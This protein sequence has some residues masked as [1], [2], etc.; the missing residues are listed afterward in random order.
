MKNEKS[1]T[2]DAGRDIA[3]T[4]GYAE[5]FMRGGLPAGA[6]DEGIHSF[7]VTV[8]AIRSDLVEQYKANAAAIGFGYLASYEKFNFGASIANLGTKL[9]Y[10][11]EGDPLPVTLRTGAAVPLRV[12]DYIKLLMAYDIVHEER[13]FHH[14]AGAE[15]AFSRLFAVR[16][17]WRF[18]PE[19]YQGGLTFGFGLNLNR[20]FIEYAYGWYGDMEDTHRVL[21]GV[22]FLQ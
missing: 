13:V 16:G 11:D 18:E 8:T 6:L 4:F 21:F 20:F 9:K 7:G 5:N 2:L 15:L 10:L 14:R 19:S 17:G 12:K 1:E 3:L 22:K